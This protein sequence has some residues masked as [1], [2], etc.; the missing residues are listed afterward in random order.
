[1]KLA[2]E[3]VFGVLGS[4]ALV[5]FFAAFLAGF[6]LTQYY[7]SGERSSLLD[8]MQQSGNFGAP[9]EAYR[10][11]G[12]AFWKIRDRGLKLFAICLGL[13]AIFAV[14]NSVFGELPGVER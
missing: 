5:S 9:K 2:S 14:I 7:D 13:C 8:R 4:V 11:E 12:W 6:M 3:I 10:R 1:M